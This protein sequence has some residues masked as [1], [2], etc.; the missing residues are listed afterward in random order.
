MNTA[1][2]PTETFGMNRREAIRRT[3]LLLGTA[4]SASTITGVMHA[5]T[6]RKGARWKP[7]HLKGAQA[8]TAGAFA[9]RILPKTDTPGALD[10]GVPEFIDI[11]YGKYM[12]EEEKSVFVKGLNG[13]N[14]ASRKAHDKPFRQL[15]AEQQDGIV[16]A[17]VDASGDQKKFY[18]KIREVTLTGYFTSEVVGKEVL[19]YDPIPGMYQGCVPISELGNR[20]WTE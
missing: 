4:V 1:S 10:A 11:M 2:N 19:H 15:T 5:Q 20:A 12:S 3:A 6:A 16:K 18:Q 9:E 7:S 14:R 17:L 13:V 8:S